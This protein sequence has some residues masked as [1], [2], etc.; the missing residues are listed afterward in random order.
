M[1][2]H[3]EKL[4]DEHADRLLRKENVV[5]VAGGDEKLLVYV[6]RKR[7]LSALDTA[8]VVD[9]VIDDVETVVIETGEIRPL[10]APGTSIGLR[11]QGTGTLGAVVRDIDRPHVRYALTNNHV[12]A[13]SN[14]AMALAAI[15]SPGPADGLGA[16]VGTLGR[17]EPIYFDRDNRVDAALVRLPDDTPLT[18]PGRTFTPQV[19]WSVHKVGRTTAHTIGTVTGNNATI[20]V[21]FGTQGSARFRGQIVTT[22]MLEAGDSGSLLTTSGGFPCGLCFAG[23]SRISIHNPIRLAMD[24]L[25]FRF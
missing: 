2:E 10:F 23:G 13:N 5:G 1:S 18:H 22:N 16:V 11:N 6:T 15:H 8:D 7:P 17:F 20:S 24:T 19:R 12:A 4:V 3:T 21:N 9:E 25:G 14:K